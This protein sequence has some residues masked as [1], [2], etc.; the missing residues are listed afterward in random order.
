MGDEKKGRRKKTEASKA[1]ERPV[2]TTDERPLT[3]AELVG[4]V[5]KD[6]E[7]KLSR[8]ELKPTVGDF[9]RLVQLKKELD[10]EQPREIEV[11]WVEP[12]QESEKENAPEE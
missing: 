8:N 5:I 9:I 1:A 3:K 7:G 11:S 10:E 2:E 12:N 4:N 6:I